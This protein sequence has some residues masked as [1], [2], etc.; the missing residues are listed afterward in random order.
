MPAEPIAAQVQSPSAN[1][2]ELMQPIH[3]RNTTSVTLCRKSR[4]NNPTPVTT[5][6]PGSWEHWRLT[7]IVLAIHW[8]PQDPPTIPQHD[9]WQHS[10]GHINSEPHSTRWNANSHS[11]ACI[12]QP[13]DI[14]SCKMV[15]IHT[16]LGNEQT[17][18]EHNSLTK[19]MG[20]RGLEPCGPG[21][22]MWRV[23]PCFH[24]SIS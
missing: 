3:Y 14:L 9:L 16:H 24:K 18:W 11:T 6:P 1:T 2:P 10:A 17:M 4:K 23:P 12:S 8:S 13:S 21:F 20:K 22:P 15:E 19:L 7:N 5:M